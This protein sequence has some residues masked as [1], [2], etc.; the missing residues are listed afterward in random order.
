MMT[1]Q[2]FILWVNYPFKSIILVVPNPDNCKADL[3]NLVDIIHP[4]HI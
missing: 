2:N 4:A 3:E 1:E